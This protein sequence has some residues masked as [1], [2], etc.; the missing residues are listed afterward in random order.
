MPLKTTAA[1]PTPEKRTADVN[2]K[3]PSTSLHNLDALLLDLDGVVTATARVH[4]EAWKAAF[5]EYLE[6]RAARLGSRFV[7]FSLKDDYPRYVDGKPRLDGVA[8]FLQSR[9]IM[10]PR[11]Q[12]T[13]PPDKETVCGLGNRKNRKFLA[14]VREMGVDV[15]ESSVDFIKQAKARGLK[16]AIVTSS[17]NCQEILTVARLDALFDTAVDGVVA[18]HCML[19]GKPAPDTYQEAARRLGV[20]AS[21]AAVVEDA[22]AG[23]K[24][25]RAGN[26]GLVI[27]VDR[28]GE[29]GL[30]RNAGAD[31]VVSDLGD[32]TFEDTDAQPAAMP[33][34]ALNHLDE[35]AARVADKRIA[36]FLDYDGTLTPIV[37]R[38]DLAVLPAGMRDSLKDLAAC[39][40][41]VIVSGRERANVARLV[42]L[43]DIVYAGAHGFDISGPAGTEIQ[44]AEG[45]SYVPAIR[46][47][48]EELSR[49]LASI[50]GV[51]VEDKTYALA[52]HFRLVPPEQLPTIEKALD[53][54]LGKHP[55]LRRT[56]GKKIFE[57]RPDIDWDKGKAVLWLL[58]ALKLH[59]EDVVPFYLGDDLTDYDAFRA[60]RGKGLSLLVSDEPQAEDVDYRLADTDEVRQFLDA[61]TT[62]CRRKHT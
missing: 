50:D 42:G 46:E 18:H 26:F 20:P 13:D 58:D 60:L 55:Q 49:R 22:I 37:E 45:S 3:R 35:I 25:G 39:C 16:V 53:E 59:G 6:E 1:T 40:T 61:L 17:R 15:F 62:V 11:G 12:D 19:E 7:P 54:V 41:V 9:N 36:V 21:R 31:I 23:V 30:L 29:P 34:L 38:P 52:V 32:L 2:D 33:P 56:G 44:H 57:L 8:S 28:I 48:A 43:E 47:A 14:V 24:A 51:I 10:L 27:G 5:D 4:A